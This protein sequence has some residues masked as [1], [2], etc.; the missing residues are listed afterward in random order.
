VNLPAH[1]IQ[2]SQ[3]GLKVQG[4]DPGPI[5]GTWGP[6][7]QFAYERYVSLNPEQS[8][9]EP[10][11]TFSAWFAKQGIR[12]FSDKEVLFRGARDAKL[13]LNTD[14]PRASWPAIIPTLRVL[15]LLRDSVGSPIRLISIY[16]S[17]AY[18]SRIGGEKNSFHTKFC[19][20]DFQSDFVS[21]A[22]LHSA[23]GKMRTKGVFKGGLG[24]YPKF[25][26]V[27]TRGYNANW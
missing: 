3:L 18:N 23:L 2:L 1:I 27:D 24:L 6:L 15:D 17:P 13:K 21:S 5:D 20:I 11:E 8:S 12:H 7:T 26:H 4:L 25:V 9:V 16:R 19:A 10:S 14:P 22:V